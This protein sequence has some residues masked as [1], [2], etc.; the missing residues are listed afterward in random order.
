[1]EREGE[2]E[3]QTKTTESRVMEPMGFAYIDGFMLGYW[4]LGA[5]IK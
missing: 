1:M 5:L 2:T 3:T 4:L